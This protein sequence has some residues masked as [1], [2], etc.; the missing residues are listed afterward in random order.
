MQKKNLVIFLT[1]VAFLVLALLWSKQVDG[2]QDATTNP[3]PQG[4][5]TITHFVI[6]ASL[7]SIIEKLPF[8]HSNFNRVSS[9]NT[10]DLAVQNGKVNQTP[11]TTPAEFKSLE[12][13]VPSSPDRKLWAFELKQQIVGPLSQSD[14]DALMDA[15]N[16]LFQN[17]NKIAFRTSTGRL[18]PSIEPDARDVASATTIQDG[19]Y[20]SSTDTTDTKLYY[21]RTVSGSTTKVVVQPTLTCTGKTIPT[22]ASATQTLTAAQLAAATGSADAVCADLP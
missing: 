14:V 1:A 4:T 18:F 22:Y 21:V 20:K 11:T 12:N 10:T 17:K 2:F 16:Q 8:V 9:Y 13:L 19:Y 7:Q 15:S 5:V 3:L 6:Y